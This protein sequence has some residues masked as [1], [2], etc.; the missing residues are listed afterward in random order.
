MKKILVMIALALPMLASAQKFGYINTQE[1][2]TQMPE[3]NNVKTEM[4]AL[5]STYEN[6][7]ATMQEEF[8]KKLQEYQQGEATMPDAMKELKQQELSDMQQRIQLFYQTA[9]QDIERKQQELLA[10]I[11][12]KMAKAIEEVGKEKSFT[13]IFDAAAMVHIG[14]DATNVMPD[15]K[16]K[17]NIK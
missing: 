9:Q 4:D 15:V 3:L 1:L 11:H 7:I 2:F 16:A 17:L 14:A 13:F 10:P 8:N 6:Q 5:Q 12:E